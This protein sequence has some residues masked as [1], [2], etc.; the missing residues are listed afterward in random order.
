MAPCR[1]TAIAVGQSLFL[2]ALLREVPTLTNV[3]EPQTAIDVGP[4]SLK[5]IADSPAVL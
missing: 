5:A 1:A 2:N 4:L 3:V